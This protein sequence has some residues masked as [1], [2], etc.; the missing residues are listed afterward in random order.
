M[1]KKTGV[2]N[3]LLTGFFIFSLIFTP[4]INSQ[5]S[6]ESATPETATPEPTLKPY[7]PDLD[8]DKVFQI[9]GEK[10]EDYD[11]AHDDY[12]LKKAQ[13]LRFRTLKSQT[14]AIAST[15]TMLQKRDEV[16]IYFIKSL[17]AKLGG[18]IGIS[19][20][21]REALNF[22][23]E[24]EIFWFEGHKE[25]LTSA[26]SLDDLVRDSGE[27]AD[28]YDSRATLFYETLS[29]ISLG[30]INDFKE[31]ITDLFTNIKEKVEVIR[32]EERDEYKFSERKI[33]ILDRWTL[34]SDNKIARGVE[35]QAAAEALTS[36][37]QSSGF[38]GALPHYDRILFTL[39]EAQLFYREGSSFLKEVVKEI[40]IAE[41]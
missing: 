3:I 22:R 13:Y 39:G 36:N 16:V 34:E 6:T 8:F 19:D 15:L 21:R 30:K 14:D 25:K 5:E 18:G 9:Y 24:A 41:E 40:T 32:K 4:V 27:A 35:K 2:R 29:V 33:Q 28:R 23:L 17:R 10:Q 37:F 20:A 26:G 31:R 38:D 1:K 11:K 7:D 12:V